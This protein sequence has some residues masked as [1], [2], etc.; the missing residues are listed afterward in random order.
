MP[1][2]WSPA[3]SGADRDE[4]VDWCSTRFSRT[5]S[6]GAEP[7]YLLAKRFESEP[8]GFPVTLDDFHRGLVAAGLALHK[9]AEHQVYVHARWL[10]LPPGVPNERAGTLH[11]VVEMYA[12]RTNDYDLRGVVEAIGLGFRPS[13][14]G[15]S[16]WFWFTREAGIANVSI[17]HYNV[18]ATPA[19]G[20][21]FPRRVLE[22]LEEHELS[23]VICAAPDQIVAVNVP[24]ETRRGLA[25]ELV[26]LVST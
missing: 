21:V 13:L 11:R 25:A 26:K 4:L 1:A 12:R 22:A 10:G 8:W 20:E 19:P 16:L 6:V 23:R 9:G 17:D 7:T 24:S 15:Q 18:T 5:R 3:L 14:A 2:Q